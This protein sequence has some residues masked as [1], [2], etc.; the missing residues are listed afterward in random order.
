MRGTC[1]YARLMVAMYLSGMDNKALAEKTGMT[2]S[3]L[4]R[5]LRGQ[6]RINLEEAHRIRN[7]LQCDLPLEKLFERAEDAND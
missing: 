4:R 3:S 2:Y 6:T 1:V 5:K 7:A